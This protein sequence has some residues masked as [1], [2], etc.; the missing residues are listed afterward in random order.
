MKTKL[1]ATLALIVAALMFLTAC[2]AAAATPMPAV[3]EEPAMRSE[4]AN[5]TLSAPTPAIGAGE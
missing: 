5:T 3:P 2:G 1:F 4:P